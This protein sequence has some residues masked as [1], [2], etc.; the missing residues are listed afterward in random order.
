MSIESSI[1]FL[2]CYDIKKT[3]DFY[4]EKIGLRLDC[5]QGFCR[6]FD[7]GYGFW[8]FCQYDNKIPVVD[9]ICLSLNCRDEA[10]V[11]KYFE[12]M[13]SRGCEVV[14]SPQ[15]HD[16]SPVYSFFVRDPNGYLVEFQ[17][18]LMAGTSSAGE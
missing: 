7:T 13:K 14:K 12:L 5:D 15:K 4:T 9:G 1:A 18:I 10:D 6:I 11:D 16:R 2:P 8:G 3:S 17:K